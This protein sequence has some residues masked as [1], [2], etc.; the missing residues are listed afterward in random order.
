MNDDTRENEGGR[1]RGEK[2]N[3]SRRSDARL[4]RRRN[5]RIPIS[6]HGRQENTTQSN[7]CRRG[8]RN[9]AVQLEVKRATQAD[10]KGELR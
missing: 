10:H 6:K 3:E 9:F 1:R 5:R 4:M 8:E 2:K 7:R